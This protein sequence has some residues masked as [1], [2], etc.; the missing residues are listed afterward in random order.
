[1]PAQIDRANCAR[2]HAALM[3]AQVSRYPRD[4]ALT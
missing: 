3:Q 4:L 2:V 1:M